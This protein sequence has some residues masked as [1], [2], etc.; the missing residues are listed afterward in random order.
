LLL[1]HKVDPNFFDYTDVVEV[2]EPKP[3]SSRVYT[4][5]SG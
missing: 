3:S 1:L 5:R 2:W 4:D